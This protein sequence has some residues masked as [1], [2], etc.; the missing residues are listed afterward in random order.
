MFSRPA[1]AAEP[2][3]D[4]LSNDETEEEEEEDLES[5]TLYSSTG[6][7]NISYLSKNMLLKEQMPFCCPYSQVS[8]QLSTSSIEMRRGE[9]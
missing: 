6:T 2:A 8:T 4:S 3:E 9:D 7:Q 1:V 5:T